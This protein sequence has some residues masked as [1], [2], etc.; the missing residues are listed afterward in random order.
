M[1]VRYLAASPAEWQVQ[2]MGNP[3]V[4]HPAKHRTEMQAFLQGWTTCWE[5]LG[6]LMQTG[7]AD[8][9]PVQGQSFS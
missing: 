3:P 8:Q 9:G 6:T 2:M 1:M 4:D 5:T 7:S